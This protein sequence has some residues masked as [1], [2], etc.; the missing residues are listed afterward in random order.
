M[1][2]VDKVA[3]LMQLILSSKEALVALEQALRVGDAKRVEEVK[4]EFISLNQT[5]KKSLSELK[6]KS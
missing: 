3:F 2:K 4:K 1:I 6:A 5:I